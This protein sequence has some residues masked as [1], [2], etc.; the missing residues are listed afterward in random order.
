MRSSGDF[1]QARIVCAL[2]CLERSVEL[3]KGTMAYSRSWPFAW[4]G[5]NV[6]NMI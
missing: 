1:R 2:L 4:Q 5:N 3:V 6:N